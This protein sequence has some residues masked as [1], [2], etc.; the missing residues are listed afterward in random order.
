MAPR[1]KTYGTRRSYAK[2]A[3]ELVN[4][5]TADEPEPR[6][7]RVDVVSESRRSGKVKIPGTVRIE[8]REDIPSQNLGE[9]DGPASGTSAG[10]G[11]L[12]SHT[13]NC[14][15]TSTTVSPMSG[16]PQNRRMSAQD[17]LPLDAS[18]KER[19]SSRKST[20]R[21]G[22]GS[23]TSEDQSLI[24]KTGLESIPIDHTSLS[25]DKAFFRPNGFTQEQQSC[26]IDLKDTPSDLN[27]LA[28]WVAQLIRKYSDKTPL[29][30]ISEPRQ[31]D[32]TSQPGQNIETRDALDNVEGVPMTRGKE[33]KRLQQLKRIEPV[34]GMSLCL[35]YF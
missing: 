12:L 32:I 6:F 11:A 28:I 22:N 35:S 2:P 17:M 10:E 34:N 16:P 23:A 1:P 7:R 4:G 26:N 29:S 13:P 33:R 14:E 19:R 15:D 5:T 27:N 9:E 25:H 30:A 20:R 21:S 31:E 8:E 24:T 3:G 18:T